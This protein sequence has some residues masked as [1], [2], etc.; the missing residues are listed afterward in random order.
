[1][2]PNI[3]IVDDVQLNVELLT[4]VLRVEGFQAWSAANGPA[5]LAMSRSA[6]GLE[7]LPAELLPREALTNSVGHGCME[8][9]TQRISCVLRAK[10]GRLLI[11]VQDQGNGFN[12]RAACDRLADLSDTHGRGVEIYKLFA[13]SV[14]FNS[15][16]NVV[17]L[18]KRFMNCE[19]I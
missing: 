7:A 3:L 10:P 16:G 8:D 5:C 2:S 4:H 15:K 1:M 18:V 17:L 11:A 19:K 6:P 12:W 13:T 14:R 9:A